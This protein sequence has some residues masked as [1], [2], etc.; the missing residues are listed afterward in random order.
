MCITHLYAIL[1]SM[2]SEHTCVDPDVVLVVGGAGK[3]PTTSLLITDVRPLSSVCA[4]V[5]FPYVGGG[6]GSLTS[7]K[8]ALKGALTL[9]SHC[10]NRYIYFFDISFIAV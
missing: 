9:N 4:D 10:M 8:G 1:I 5:Y 7:L 3:S 6:K 2:N